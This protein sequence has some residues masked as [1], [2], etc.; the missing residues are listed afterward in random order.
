MRKPNEPRERNEL[1]NA[2]N[3]RRE[4][5]ERNERRLGEARGTRRMSCSR[6]RL[7]SPSCTFHFASYEAKHLR[8]S[9]RLASSGDAGFSLRLASLRTRRGESR[10]GS[11]RAHLCWPYPKSIR[12]ARAFIGIVVYYRIFIQGFATTAAPIFE[13]F[14]KG[15]RFS[16]TAERQA[17]MDILKRKITEAPVLVS[18]DF[19]PAAGIIYLQ[20]DASTTIGWGGILSQMQSDG[21]IQPARYES[22]IWSNTEKRYDAVRLECRGLLKAL[23]KFRFWLYGRYF[24]LETDAQTL[25]WLLNQPPNDLPNAMMTRWLTYIRLFDF[26]VKHIRGTKNGGADALSQRGRAP[27][28]DIEDEDEADDYFDAKLYG[29]TI[30]TEPPLLARVYLHEAEYDGEDL[31][32]GRY[33]ETLQRPDGLTDQQYQSLRKKSRHFLIRDGCLF[34]RSRRRGQPPRRVIGTEL[35]RNEILVELH[36][37]T[38]HRGREVTYALVSRRYQW[39]GMYD[40]VAKFVQSCE[41][42]QRRKRIRYEEPLHPTWSIIVWEKVG[43]DVVFMPTSVEGYEFIV[44]ARDDLSGWLE[45][46]PLQHANSFSVATFIYEDLICRH[47][48]PQ[49]IVMDSGSEN[50]GLTKILL[51]RYHVKNV[52]ISAYHPQSN[53]LVERGH[54]PVVNA[55]TKYARNESVNWPRYLSLVLWA[56]RISLRRSTGYSAFELL[57][58]RECLLPVDLDIL[59]WRMVD[60]EDVKDREDL[61]RARMRQLDQRALSEAR[62][63]S[64]LEHSRQANKDYFDDVMRQRPRDQQLRI[65]DL[66]LLFN[67]HKDYWRAGRKFK[68]VDNWSGPY[69]IWEVSSAGYYRLEELDGTRAAQSVAGNRLKRFFTRRMREPALQPPGDL[70]ETLGQEVHEGP[71]GEDELGQ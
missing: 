35:A 65:G 21:R 45:A 52:H 64:D 51:E 34:K 44:F 23:K 61:I 24:L 27:S 48:L 26:D 70:S 3:E 16:W 13:V 42:C 58:G 10:V 32:L 19:A 17:A 28:E 68:L 30:A 6:G 59:S 7:A 37:K 54:G 66:V 25:V 56:D 20:V 40:D 60:W 57:Y 63:S 36:D 50:L 33:L 14:R 9:P 2:T 62:A 71:E 47:G 49:R 31:I 55:L 41:E 8:A 4:R 11:P 15:A 38:G 18:H 29:I 53:G 1:E 67:Q 46:R 12:D 43:I 39:K 5:R 22:G 69:R